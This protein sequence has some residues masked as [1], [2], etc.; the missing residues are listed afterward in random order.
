MF[1]EYTNPFIEVTCKYINASVSISD[2]WDDNIHSLLDTVLT[3]KMFSTLLL[4]KVN[5]SV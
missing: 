3:K 5:L 1:I 4:L 2:P